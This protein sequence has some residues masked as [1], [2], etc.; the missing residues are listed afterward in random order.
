MMKNFILFFFGIV[1]GVGGYHY[2]GT[3]MAKDISSDLKTHLAEYCKNLN[4]K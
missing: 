2:Y 3:W 4:N 1:L